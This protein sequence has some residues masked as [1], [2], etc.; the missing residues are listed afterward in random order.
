[1]DESVAQSSAEAEVSTASLDVSTTGDSGSSITIKVQSSKK[2]ITYKLAKVCT[3]KND[4]TCSLVPRPIPLKSQI[5]QTYE[6][7]TV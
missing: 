1:M 4:S 3:I 2:S 7:L 5:H 6:I